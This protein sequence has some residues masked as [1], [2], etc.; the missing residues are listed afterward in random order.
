MEF[1]LGAVRGLAYNV[2]RNVTLELAY[3]YIDLGNASTGTVTRLT[4]ASAATAPDRISG[5]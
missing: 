5:T 3:R 1:C 4:A 2:T